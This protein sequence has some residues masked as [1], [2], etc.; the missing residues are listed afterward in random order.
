MRKITLLRDSL[1]VDKTAPA[2]QGQTYGMRLTVNAYDMPA[3]VFVK[4][5]LA[6]DGSQDVLVAIASAE[7]LEDLPINEPTLP[8]SSFFRVSSVEVRSLNPELL[9]NAYAAIVGELLQLVRNLDALDNQPDVTAT[10]EIVSSG[11]TY[12]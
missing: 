10:A 9:D 5:R 8:D 6:Q 7:Q 11:V 12:S 1:P 3:E 4:Q 2:H